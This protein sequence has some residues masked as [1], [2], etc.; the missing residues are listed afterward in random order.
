MLGAHV[1]VDSPFRR[2]KTS[3]LGLVFPTMLLMIVINDT[4]AI[5]LENA[6]NE[7]LSGEKVDRVVQET[8]AKSNQFEHANNEKWHLLNQQNKT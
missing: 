1:L 4:D 7:V 8:L 3:F 5:D 2:T 6:Q